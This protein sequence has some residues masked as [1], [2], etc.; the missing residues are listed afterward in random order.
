MNIPWNSYGT[1]VVPFFWGRRCLPLKNNNGAVPW[2]PS[3][4]AAW[5]QQGLRCRFCCKF[6][7]LYKV[8]HWQQAN[9]TKLTMGQT[10]GKQTIASEIASENKPR[11][12]PTNL[13]EGQTIGKEFGRN[14]WANTRKWTKKQEALMLTKHPIKS[15]S[16][17]LRACTFGLSHPRTFRPKLHMFPPDR[18]QRAGVAQA[19]LQRI[20]GGLTSPG[21]GLFCT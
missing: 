1:H 13:F 4:E 9:K 5:V 6:C 10:I 12:F 11:G 18:F 21:T 7:P 20:A 8:K 15:D 19:A 2:P 14:P 3:R 17:V 16:K